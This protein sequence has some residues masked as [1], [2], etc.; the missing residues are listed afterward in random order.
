MTYP[1]DVDTPAPAQ[2][3]ARCI[4]PARQMADRLT[5]EDDEMLCM[6]N[7]VGE[8]FE[9]LIEFVGCIDVLLLRWIFIRDSVRHRVQSTV[10]R[11]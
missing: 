11:F 9:F 8:L 5:C 4:S 1:V 3:R 7:P 10:V 2:Q 6:P